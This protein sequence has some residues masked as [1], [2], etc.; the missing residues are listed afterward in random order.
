MYDVPRYLYH[1]AQGGKVFN[2]VE[3]VEEAL[4][5][6]WSMTPNIMNRAEELTEKI[7][8]HK[9]QVKVLTEELMEMEEEKATKEEIETEWKCQFCGRYCATKIGLMSHEVAC[10]KNPKNIKADD[11][12]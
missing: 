1:K 2:T 10:K 6:G 11:K 8:W 4:R 7:L 3:E 9:E 12:E 5:D